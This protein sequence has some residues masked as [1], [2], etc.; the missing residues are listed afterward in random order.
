MKIHDVNVIHLVM[1]STTM[2]MRMRMRMMMTSRMLMRMTLRMLM[3]MKLASTM[4]MG[5][6]MM[7]LTFNLL[8]LVSTWSLTL[9]APKFFPSQG[10]ICMFATFSTNSIN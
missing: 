2:M 9:T 8:K 5:M 7:T 1:T 4:L 3:G 10:L 6:R